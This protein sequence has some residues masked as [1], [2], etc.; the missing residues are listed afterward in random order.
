MVYGAW[1]RRDKFRVRETGGGE[2]EGEGK[3]KTKVRQRGKER[4]KIWI[5][6]CTNC[7]VQ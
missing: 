3:K 2:K 4:G 6:M 5:E 7:I 1:A